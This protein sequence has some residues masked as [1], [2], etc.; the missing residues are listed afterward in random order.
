M[1][2]LRKKDKIFLS[3][4]SHYFLSKNHN[5]GTLD[6]YKISQINSIIPSLASPKSI[7]FFK[8]KEMLLFESIE[9]FFTNYLSLNRKELLKLLREI[10]YTSFHNYHKMHSCYF[11]N[12]T[13]RNLMNKNANDKFIIIRERNINKDFNKQH[14]FSDSFG[15]LLKEI[16][17]HSKPKPN[18][19]GL[20]DDSIYKIEKLIQLIKN[21]ESIKN[22]TINNKIKNKLCSSKKKKRPSCLVANDENINSFNLTNSTETNFNIHNDNYKHKHRLSFFKSPLSISHH[23]TGITNIQ[24][25]KSKFMHEIINKVFLSPNTVHNNNKN[26][27]LN[28]TITSPRQTTLTRGDQKHPTCIQLNTLSPTRTF[29]YK[30]N[31]IQRNAI[32]YEKPIVVK[33]GNYVHTIGNIPNQKIKNTFLDSYKYSRNVSKQQNNSSNTLLLLANSPTICS[34]NMRLQHIKLK[35]QYKATKKAKTTLYLPKVN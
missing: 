13:L 33:S 15:L 4:I 30:P 2:F 26:K 22:N 35:S 25:N 16:P 31:Q 3:Q 23:K 9:E 28:K 20:N 8:Y 11:V 24:K 19:I 32:K 5:I 21:Q 10:Y 14:C 1:N 17:S 29:F 6:N 12:E 18:Y 34:E 27:A 7:L